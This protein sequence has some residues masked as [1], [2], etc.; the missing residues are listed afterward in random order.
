[1]TQADHTCSSA[2]CQW[3]QPG[4]RAPAPKT[5][6]LTFCSSM[7]Q[8]PENVQ[9]EHFLFLGN[10][11]LIL[12]RTSKVAVY[13]FHLGGGGS[14]FQSALPLF[15]SYRCVRERHPSKAIEWSSEWLNNML[16]YRDIF[17]GKFFSIKATNTWNL[18]MLEEL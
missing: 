10:K 5:I 12:V 18:T 8:T 11:R 7:S 15:S 6:I 2:G 9:G 1:M 14:I 4:Q 16:M 17:M 3:R 13:C